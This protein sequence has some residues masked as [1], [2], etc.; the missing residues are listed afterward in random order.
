LK[1]DKNAKQVE[2]VPSNVDINTVYV[3][4]NV[5][6]ANK[7]KEMGVLRVLLVENN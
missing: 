5:Q 6:V 2:S 1:Y 4:S 7:L 3:T